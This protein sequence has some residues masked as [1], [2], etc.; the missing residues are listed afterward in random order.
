MAIALAVKEDETEGYVSHHYYQHLL[1]LDDCLKAWLED[2]MVKENETEVYVSH[3]YYQPFLILYDHLKAWLEAVI[4]IVRPTQKIMMIL[5]VYAMVL[6]V[7]TE[8]VCGS[9]HELLSLGSVNLAYLNRRIIY[10][11]LGE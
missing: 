7:Y 8:N 9:A 5:T 1:I 6:K 10:F 11:L 3:R 4:A 2:V